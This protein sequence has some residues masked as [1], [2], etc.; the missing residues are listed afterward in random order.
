MSEYNGPAELLEDG[1]PVENVDVVLSHKVE[2]VSGLA[3]WSG[4]VK[5]SAVSSDWSNVNQIRLPPDAR[6]GQIIL[7]NIKITSG[8]GPALQAANIV[9]SGDPPFDKD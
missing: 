2:S 5:P 4:R 7:S 9:G 6:V 1:L 3:S 8:L